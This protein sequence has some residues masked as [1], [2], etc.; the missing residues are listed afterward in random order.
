MNTL[1]PRLP[2]PV[3]APA[4][5]RGIALVVVLS[6][7]VLLTVLIVGF[8]TR[9]GSERMSAVN[10]RTAASARE[11][12]D[13][14]VNLVQAQINH[15]TTQGPTTVWASQPGA[16][17]L[18]DNAGALKQI[19]R[20]YSARSVT[21]NLA[22]DLD[23]D[24]PPTA[25]ASSPAVWTDLNA[26][27][28]TTVSGT[29]QASF[30]ILDPRDPADPT[31][32][33]TMDG[34][35][36]T[37]PPGAQTDP[38]KSNYQPVPMPTRW[39]YVLQNGE[40]IAPDDGG[41]GKQLTFTLAVARPSKANPIVGRVAY[42]TDDESCRLNINT[43]SAGKATFWDTPRFYYTDEVNA[44]G[45]GLA[46]YQPAVG[47]FQRYPGHPATTTLSKVFTALNSNLTSN[48]LFNL[49][50]RFAYGGS[51]EATVSVKM[52]API[53][54]SPKNTYRLYTSVGELLFDK[55]RQNN[56]APDAS[57][58]LTR[59]QLETARFFLTAHSVAPEVNAFGKP[60]VS[61]WPLHNNNTG[62]FRS[63]V[64]Q[65][66]AFCSTLNGKLY[67][68]ARTDPASKTVD[69][70]LQRNQQLLNYLDTLTST[71]IPGYGGDF[72]TKYGADQRQIL[73]EIFDYVRSTNLRDPS[74]QPGSTA[75]ITPYGDAS[76]A[77]SQNPGMGQVT[78][79]V[80]PTVSGTPWSAQG[81]GRFPR[82]SE[83]SILLVGMG[84]GRSVNSSGS[85]T[86]P[87]FAV[88]SDQMPVYPGPN[89]D[90]KPPDNNTAV[91]AFFLL[92]FFDPCQGYSPLNPKFTIQVQGLDGFQM[93]LPAA[94]GGTSTYP[95]NMP[96]TASIYVG[97]QVPD[98]SGNITSYFPLTNYFDGSK[99]GGIMDFRCLCMMRQ[100]GA[101]GRSRFPFYGSIVPIPNNSGR[102]PTL[103][104]ASLTVKIYTGDLPAG[105]VPS[106]SNLVQTYKINFPAQQMPLP[107]VEPATYPQARTATTDHR[108]FGTVAHNKETTPNVDTTTTV[109]GPIDRAAYAKTNDASQFYFVINPVCDTI[110]S[111][112]PSAV[113]GDYR[114]MA[115]ATIPATAFVPHP[116]AS[117]LAAASNPGRMAYSLRI[118]TGQMYK[119][120]PPGPPPT[121]SSTPN[122]TF[123]AA[124][125]LIPNSSTN[126]AWPDVV[127]PTVNGAYQPG[128]TSQLGDWDN[129]SGDYA[130]GP[131]INRPDEGSVFTSTS[132][133]NSIPYFGTGSYNYANVGSTLFSANRQ[134]PSA[135]MFG[136]LPTGVMHQAAGV[137]APLPWQ[138]LLFR[139]DPGGH[140]GGVSPKDHLLLDLFWM[141][142]AEPY[143]ISEPCATAGKVNLNYQIVPFT[144]ITRSTA[145][146]SVLASEKVAQVPKSKSLLY[147]HTNSN[148]VTPNAGAARY[149]LN[150]SDTN[151]TLRQFKEKFDA[152][153]IF[154][155]ASEICDVFLV[156]STESWSSDATAR[157]N[158]Y[159]D[160]YALVGDNVRERPY[161]NIY[162][163]V[164][165]KSNVYTVYFTVQTLNGATGDPTKWDE[166]K[167]AVTGEFRGSTTLER[168]LDPNNA[169][170]LDYAETANL[171]T[172]RTLDTFYKWRVVSNTQFAP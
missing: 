102:S 35:K 67:E 138:T 55:N 155:T 18:F 158:W 57:K 85:V 108:R 13:T 114:L 134:L 163:R 74:L 19:Y 141:P 30:P 14:A 89:G 64:D 101:D 133:P 120:M 121:A 132:D 127:P 111:M 70:Q 92:N 142:V 23:G 115:N 105:G 125:H 139:P 75:A 49:S 116:K 63:A 22:D 8:M 162:P 170:L 109:D 79:T 53:S 54:T 93:T 32:L 16:V 62:Q 39:L 118:A 140:A 47:E 103:A 38:T 77:A 113:Y 80:D 168:Y 86:V 41:N 4:P 135:V 24:L 150:L 20:L 59:Q 68:F 58:Q 3:S 21:T 60:R 45:S 159:G 52:S 2:A 29:S 161:A 94:D 43:A 143:A 147:K 100:L 91:Q 149:S 119:Y 95:L 88:P 46:W 34:F 97:G 84:Q 25:W 146:Q 31:K 71:S 164:T 156:P 136:S 40:I 65:L 56:G 152:H 9:A 172:T 37:N 61:I 169:Q 171:T 83:A 99:R 44:P 160:N 126:S 81:F 110:F 73:T 5:E 98:A 153:N 165:T 157:S 17:R 6:L 148:N 124:G 1:R 128:S 122:P 137:A 82:I 90:N 28:S 72:R 12:A 104:N 96:A 145:L 27:A 51:Q 76:S 123:T 154:K 129:A 144:Y 26:P 69:V 117:E 33:V 87:A 112:V 66:I 10:Y 167:G 166:A 106:D 107:L 151:G 36:L 7:V 131:Y 78:P 50:P 48:D 11:L 15:A 130:D 42:W